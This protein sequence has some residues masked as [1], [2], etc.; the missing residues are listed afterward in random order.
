MNIQQTRAI[1]FAVDTAQE[2]SRKIESEEQAVALQIA[3][4]FLQSEELKL[5]EST[6]NA[7]GH[8]LYLKAIALDECKRS[9]DSF[10]I[11]VQLV[12]EYPGWD[13]LE[14]SLQIV[15]NK[16]EKTAMDLMAVSPEDKKA[17]AI[18]QLLET[19]GVVGVQLR[20][21]M[22]LRD[23]SQG[24]KQGAWTLAKAMLDLNPDDHDY[25]Q[26]AMEVTEAAG[27]H[28][29]RR[30]LLNHIVALLE[31]RPYRYELLKALKEGDFEETKVPMSI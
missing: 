26:I 14:R 12:Q 8:F 31:G 11:L 10:E 20:R 22:L 2:I 24:N 19:Y 21:I 3:E 17:H 7:R 9:E 29:E 28:Q 1:K 16:L 6:S 4:N 23:V 30:K 5:I 15:L 18:Y 25:L 27:M 13:N